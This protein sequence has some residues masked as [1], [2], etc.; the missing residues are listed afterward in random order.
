MAKRE[1]PRLCIK[2]MTELV[3]TWDVHGTATSVVCPNER[4]DKYKEEK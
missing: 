4:C 1:Q 3:I 2:C